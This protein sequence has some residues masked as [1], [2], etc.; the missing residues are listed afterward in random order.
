MAEKFSVLVKNTVGKEEISPIRTMLSK[1]LCCRH[2]KKTGLF[3]KGLKQ[4][5]NSS[6]A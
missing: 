5:S 2:V 3:G 4:I 6:P 1:E